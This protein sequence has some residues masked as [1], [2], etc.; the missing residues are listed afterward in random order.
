M[1][2]LFMRVLLLLN[3]FRR[4]RP[5]LRSIR[6]HVFQQAD[7]EDEAR[8]A[9]LQFDPLWDELL[10]PSKLRSSSFWSS[11]STCGCMALRF[12]WGPNGLAGLV[13]EVAAT[14]RAAA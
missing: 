6:G 14:R 1:Y 3:A 10:P 7:T 5:R 8:E 2:I 11:G 9:L 4:R 12:G 13:R